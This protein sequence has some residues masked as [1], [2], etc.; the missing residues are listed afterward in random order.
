M[1]VPINDQWQKT[2]DSSAKARR[3]IIIDA[4]GSVSGS[5]ITIIDE[6]SSTVTYI[7]E[8][9]PGTATSSPAWRIKKII[10]NGTVTEIKYADANTLYD[11]I[12][13]NRASLTYG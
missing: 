12:W 4:D 1:P 3:V 5:V 8:A 13:D 9:A 2:Y 11:N 6:E 10:V 7:G